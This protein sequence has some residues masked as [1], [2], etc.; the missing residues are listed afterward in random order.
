MAPR[1]I[2]PGESWSSGIL[3]AIAAAPAM[4]LVFSAATNESPHVG[5]ELEEANG[6]GIA[7]VPVRFGPAEPSRTLRYFIGQA[8]WLDTEGVVA[9]H[10]ERALVRAVLHAEKRSNRV[11]CAA[12]DVVASAPEVLNSVADY[13]M[14][15]VVGVSMFGTRLTIAVR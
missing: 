1:D 15:G 8:E 13:A 12:P 9:E 6:Y 3:D 14:S 5:R 2:A 4:V 11:V 7:I 10:W